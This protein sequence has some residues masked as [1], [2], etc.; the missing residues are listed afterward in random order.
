MGRLGPLQIMVQ[1]T[2]PPVPEL[3]KSKGVLWW[4]G[5]KPG[6]QFPSVSR[7]TDAL[8]N[9]KPSPAPADSS[10]AAEVGCK[11]DEVEAAAGVSAED[12]R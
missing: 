2:A 4:T 9:A 7:G 10:C 6:T 12:A 11:A 8:P 5:S 1:K 3:Q